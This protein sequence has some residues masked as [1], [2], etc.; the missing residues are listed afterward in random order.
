[1][2]LG[3]LSVSVLYLVC[4][5][6]MQALSREHGAATL[7]AFWVRQ[8]ARQIVNKVSLPRD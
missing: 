1:M 2:V 7:E 5:G 3:L 6:L 4:R 8:L